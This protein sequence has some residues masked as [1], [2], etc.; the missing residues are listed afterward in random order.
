[1]PT[2]ETLQIAED[3][4]ETLGRRALTERQ[5]KLYSQRSRRDMG[6]EGL[7]S[8]AP[9]DVPVYLDE[10]ML[11]LHC[12]LI[13]READ[14][15]GPW[16]Q[17][18]RRAAEI[19]EW[20]S[21]P[22]LRPA[23][24]PVHLLAAAAYQLAGYPAMALGHLRRMPDNE[25]FSVIL[26]EFLRADFP[27][28]L[29][30]VRVF[31][32]EQRAIEAADPIAPSDLAVAAIR[33]TVMC[34]GTVCAY[35]RSGGDTMVERA[36]LKLDDLAASF[37][38]SRD[39]YSYLLAR[40]TA[41]TCHCYV[42]TCL[43]PHIAG[44]QD[45]SSPRAGDA[46]VQFGRAAFVNRRMLVWPA[47]SAGIARLRENTSFVLCTPT[48]SGKTAVATLAVIQG[49]F[50][51]PVRQIPGLEGI[52]FGSIILYLVPSRALAAEV[53]GR[54]AQD[55]VGI[56][57]EPVVV[58]GLY[59]GVD[60]GPTDA[61]IQTG[62]PTIVICT[63]EKADALLRYLGV[64]FLDRVRLIVIDEAHMVEQNASQLENLQDASSR[65]YRLEQLGTRL[66]HAQGTFGFRL[67]ALSAVAAR[68]A[69][70]LARWIG[71]DVDASPA[72]SDYRST[73]QMLGRL[74][75]SAAGQFSIGYD[76]MDG[77]SLQFEDEERPASPYVPL[78]FPPVP[79]G[80]APD[81]GPEIAMRAPTLWAA[82]HLA[83]ERSDG[84]RP[85]VLISLTQNIGTFA[86]SCA[87]Q[88]DAWPAEQLPNYRAVD[89][90]DEKWTRCLAVA[91]DYFTT[92]SVEYR[93]LARGIAV[94]H[95][96][97]PGLLARRLKTVID[98]GF[99]RVVIA[100]STLSEGV[101][102]PVNYVLIPN[103]C[104]GATTLSLQE[105]TNLIGRAGR[106]G[107]ATE[108]HAFVVLPEGARRGRQWEGYRSL[109]AAMKAATEAA[110]EGMPEDAASSSLIHL[111][112]AL[113]G[114]WRELTGGGTAQEFTNWLERTAV[115]E[116]PDEPPLAIRY[117]DSLDTFLLAAIQEVEEL[118]GRELPPQLVEEE[119]IRI[120]QRT[121]AFA[122]SRD[123][124][125][126]QRIW[127][128]RGR[129]IKERYPDPAQR[130]KIYKTSL[131][132]RSAVALVDQVE[133]V[134][135]KLLEGTAY[136]AWETEERLAF[137]RDV[138][139]QLSGVPSFRISTQFRRRRNF[140][141]WPRL[142][143]WWLAKQTLVRQP[144]PGD[145]SS[146][147]D[148]VAQN[149]I[150]RGAWGLG[151][152]L[153][154]LLD[155][156]DDDQPIRALEIADWP[157]SGLPW[158]AFWLKELITW[159]TLDPVAAFLLARGNAI[160]RPQAEAE[161]HAYYAALPAN[162]DANDMLDPRSIRDWINAQRVRPDQAFRLYGLA[163]DVDLE[164]DVAAYATEQLTVVPT[165]VDN[166][167]IWID[168]AGYT[169]AQS[170]KPA[171]WPAA[172]SN[173]EFTLNVRDA[174]VSGVPY[175]PYA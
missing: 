62:R 131:S 135:A 75:V 54:L 149:F 30:G 63:F 20:L 119:L 25:P 18:V 122:A 26:R 15:S 164:R 58:T 117:L 89:E 49:L 144:D 36:L 85:S 16:P 124:N 13:E 161:A 140:T 129:A 160:D 156:G 153:G 64:L 170:A 104:R 67:V 137:V 84:S 68:A 92:E 132:P 106:P 59:G 47:Q 169:V 29:E 33:H 82:M 21:Q 45:V 60:W 42:E 10:A 120:W 100:T 139:L 53:E 40:L 48:G 6:R 146:W 147:Y 103:V 102:I 76:L 51:E 138:L 72:T 52:D 167:L 141:D 86:T 83:A 32:N 101:N 123:E 93:L 162:M 79:G 108:G 74:E 44:L 27:A 96:K 7:R 91:A 168:P 121:Y 55:L 151:S 90:T 142:L 66:L 87:D 46:L 99:V 130:R 154:L 88:L 70:A 174:A 23:G 17:S 71:A 175:L 34:I 118:R 114:A 158:I 81:T 77:R 150:Y 107:V 31:W 69:P 41:A 9:G 163:I 95:G 111:L 73:R 2:A 173:Y 56:A 65:A 145:I 61:W 143:R 134:K 43:W 39:P 116:G 148:F 152:V 22:D 28:A 112:G 171:D 37:R 5:A 109:V 159:G 157:R 113:E 110:G 24:V 35:F 19:L 3:V 105:F 115:T 165:E 155:L 127:L 57:A 136:A 8:F 38:Y 11:L 14:L 50:A 12:A 133:I 98:C 166:R 128:G 126:L 125:R 80:I 1:M 78:P 172:P 4:R 97:M 94:H